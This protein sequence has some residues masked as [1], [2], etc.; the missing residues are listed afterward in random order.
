MLVYCVMTDNPKKPKR[1]N[2]EIRQDS[3][4]ALEELK[5]RTKSASISEV[6]RNALAALDLITQNG[7]EFWYKDSEGE[8]QKVRVL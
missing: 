4:E 7:A 1:L 6:V 8:M 3:Y 5:E 2:L